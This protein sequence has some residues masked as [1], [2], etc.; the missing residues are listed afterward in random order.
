MSRPCASRCSRCRA[1]PRL[2]ARR[3][4]R[5]QRA[6]ADYL[7]VPRQRA[8]PPRPPGTG[9][10]GV[11]MS[12]RHQDQ[13]MS[14]EHRCDACG[15][16][17]LETFA[18]IGY[19]PVLCGVH[20]AD[21]TRR[22]RQSRRFDRARPVPGVRLRPQRRLRPGVDGLRHVDG[23]QPAFLAGVP[24]VLGR[25]RR[26]PRG[27]LRVGRGARARHRLRS[28]RVPA[29]AVPR[30]RAAPASAT[31]RCTPE[32]TGPI[33]PGRRS[34]APRATWRRAG[35]VRPRDLPALVRALGRPVRFP[36]RPARSRP[37]SAPSTDTS[38]CPMP[39]TTSR[40]PAGR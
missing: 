26:A 22:R 37:A 20:W 40:R 23:H 29:R 13:P 34:T 18:D 10:K 11:G 35:G 5:G 7:G 4:H 8:A 3:A 39:A 1:S 24:D 27:A 30:R 33:P 19:V 15:Q 25:A 14:S 32:P 38:R 9:P 31:T 28:G 21:P 12:D 17:T 16:A 2:A 6:A 36:Q